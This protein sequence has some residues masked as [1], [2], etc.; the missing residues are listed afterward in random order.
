MRDISRGI[1]CLMGGFLYGVGRCIQM[2]MLFVCE[3]ISEIVGLNDLINACCSRLALMC[4]YSFS[5]RNLD[6][7]QC[8][9]DLQKQYNPEVIE[10]LCGYW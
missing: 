1:V 8:R 5:C 6:V 9:F 3:Q 10:T 4:G 2:L 7:C